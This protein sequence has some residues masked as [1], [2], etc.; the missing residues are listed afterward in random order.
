[1]L[2]INFIPETKRR[3]FTKVVEQLIKMVSIQPGDFYKQVRLETEKKKS[4]IEDM[5]TIIT[6]ECKTLLLKYGE[7]I[8]GQRYL[9]TIFNENERIRN[10]VIKKVVSYFDDEGFIVEASVNK[11]MG[12]ISFY[13]GIT[14]KLV[15]YN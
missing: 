8:I 3:E 5:T 12:S 7:A 15:K 14:I 9:E 6:E 1:L 2:Y 4:I 11:Y 13:S 10:A